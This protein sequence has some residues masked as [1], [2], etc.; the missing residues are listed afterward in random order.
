MYDLVLWFVLI[1]LRVF[2][3][4]V[5]V[6]IHCETTE[7]ASGLQWMEKEETVGKQ[8]P[9]MFTQCQSRFCRSLFPCQD[10]PG[11][12]FTY[13][14]N[15]TVDEGTLIDLIL[16]FEMLK[17]LPHLIVNKFLFAN[18]SEKQMR[19]YRIMQ[20]ITK[21]WIFNCSRTKFEAIIVNVSVFCVPIFFLPVFMLLF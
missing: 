21:F 13:T 16:D 15:V 6:R 14:A 17:N 19:F 8:Q 4:Q 12:K 18:L 7:G 2:A 1:I 20:S 5:V 10:T 3:F 9:Y 11:V